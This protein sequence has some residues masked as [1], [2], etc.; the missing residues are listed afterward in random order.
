MLTPKVEY[1]IAEH[2][3]EA[4]IF[5]RFDYDAALIARVKKLVGV[6]WS[7]SK[8]AWYVRDTEQYRQKFGLTPKPIGADTLPKIDPANQ[9]AYQTYIETLQ[10]KAYSKSTINTYRNEFSQ[11]LFTLKSHKVEDLT[12]DRLR[13]YFLYCINTLH[14]SENTL[15]SRINAVK[16]YFEKVLKREKFFFE[17]P[18]PKKPS[19]LPKAIHA[20]DIK[21][22]LEATTNRK[23]NIMLK[24]C[25]GMGLRVSEIVNLKITDIDSKNMQVFIER[26]KGKKDRYVN[27]PTTILEQLRAY[28]LEYKPKKYL[29]EG[30][31]G[32]QY[33]T[34][35]A[36]K[37]FSE[38]LKKAKINKEVG[39]HGLRHS[40]ATHLLEAGTDVT[41]IQELL[42]HKDIKTTLRYTHVSKQSIKKIKSPLDNM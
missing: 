8:K 38:A 26:G 35:S 10:L 9:A 7:Q 27:L 13:S 36:Q 3:N 25:Y 42:G 11:L 28:F 14:L 6:Q 20:E 2:K 16:F 29:F 4:V 40:F 41:F 22:L 19:I 17:I 15:H 37:V 12:P 34:R 31:Y 18:R 30:Q 5:I 32:D 33:S 39:I 23:H 21:K 24:L 1:E